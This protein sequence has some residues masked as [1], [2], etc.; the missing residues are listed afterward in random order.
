MTQETNPRTIADELRV[1]RK[2]LR[3]IQSHQN[4]DALR[5]LDE[6]KRLAEEAKIHLISEEPA[7]PPML[8]QFQVNPEDRQQYGFR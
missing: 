1:I 4:R 5:T 8:V 3:R 6:I 2:A 7:P